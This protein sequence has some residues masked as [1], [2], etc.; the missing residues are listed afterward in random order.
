MLEDKSVQVRKCDHGNDAALRVRS[1][2]RLLCS[3]KPAKIGM[4][5]MPFLACLRGKAF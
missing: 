4:K 2:W 3:S 5:L 1:W